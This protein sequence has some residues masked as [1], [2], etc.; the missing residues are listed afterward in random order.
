MKEEKNGKLFYCSFIDD[1]KKNQS[2]YHRDYFSSFSSFV[3]VVVSF[4]IYYIVSILNF[5]VNFWA[6]TKNDHLTQNNIY[7]QK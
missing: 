4:Q 6:I 3:V 2:Y 5:V 1:E 7:H